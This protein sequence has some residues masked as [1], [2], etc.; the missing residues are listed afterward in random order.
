MIS[1]TSSE[2]HREQASCGEREK[3]VSSGGEQR[4]QRGRESIAAGLDDAA[5]DG[6]LGEDVEDGP[7]AADADLV[8][9]RQERLAN[10]RAQR[11][12]SSVETEDHAI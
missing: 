12:P 11:M 6:V 5:D 8:Q 2:T 3:P 7:R 10:G 9:R 4:E 1:H